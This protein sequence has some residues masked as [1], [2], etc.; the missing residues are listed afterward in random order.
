MNVITLLNRAREDEIVLPAIQ[1]DLDRQGTLKL[2]RS[3]IMVA[4]PERFIQYNKNIVQ[5]I[6]RKK[7]EYH[8]DQARQ[9]GNEADK[10]L[11]WQ[12]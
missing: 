2:S 12:I 10:R 1:R 9:A 8:L 11:V 6:F 3:N 5:N 7:E 4:D